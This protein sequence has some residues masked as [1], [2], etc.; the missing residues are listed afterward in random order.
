M[1]RE[2]QAIRDPLDCSADPRARFPTVVQRGG[3]FT[4]ALTQPGDETTPVGWDPCKE[5]RYRVNPD[6]EPQG[7]RALI[8]RAVQR[9]SDATGLAF[10]DV[11]D[12]DER[13][14]QDGVKLFGRPGTP[15]RRGRR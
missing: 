7:G 9:I 12:T 2:E 6:G 10:E 3:T 4:Y 11:G 13:P 5:I 15:G 14:F 1:K 8:D